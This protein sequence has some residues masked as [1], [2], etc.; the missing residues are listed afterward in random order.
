MRG[1]LAIAYLPV[2]QF[3]QNNIT[4]DETAVYR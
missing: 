1:I 2:S 4:N 3:A